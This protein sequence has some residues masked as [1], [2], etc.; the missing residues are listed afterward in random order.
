[1][2]FLGDDVDEGFHPWNMPSTPN[3]SLRAKREKYFSLKDSKYG[4]HE[5]LIVFFPISIGRL[6][7]GQ[8]S[9]IV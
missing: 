6:F 5:Y 4:D 7:L 1:M 9:K 3:E 8:W 2:R